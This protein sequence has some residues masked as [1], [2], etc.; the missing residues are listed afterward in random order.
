VAA[1]G[2]EVDLLTSAT[3]CGACGR[4]CGAGTCASGGCV[5]PPKDASPPPPPPPVDAAAPSDA[6]E[7][8]K[9]ASSEQ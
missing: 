5:A 8:P 6:G 7:P 4:S 2:C 9:D 3:N 1:D